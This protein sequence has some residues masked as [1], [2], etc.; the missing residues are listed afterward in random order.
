MQGRRRGFSTGEDVQPIFQAFGELCLCCGI[1]LAAVALVLSIHSFV[2]FRGQA[3]AF[4]YVLGNRELEE[5][6]ITVISAVVL[7]GWSVIYLIYR[8]TRMT[9]V[10]MV[11]WE[12][13]QQVCCPPPLAL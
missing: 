12:R 9:D 10:A 4:L 1:A 5:F 3:T 6:H 7:L 2:V 8:Q 11:D 13:P